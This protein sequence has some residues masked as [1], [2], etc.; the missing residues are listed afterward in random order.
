MPDKEQIE[1][2]FMH[3]VLKMMMSLDKVDN[4]VLERLTS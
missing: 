4:D 2:F 3:K 1:K